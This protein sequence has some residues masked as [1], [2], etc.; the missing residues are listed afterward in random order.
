[1][2]GRNGT[3][4]GNCGNPKADARLPK[5][6]RRHAVMFGIVTPVNSS[7]NCSTEV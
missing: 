6:D 4:L 2:F 3:A 7:R 5:V 1:V